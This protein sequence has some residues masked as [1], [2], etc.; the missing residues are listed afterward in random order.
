M[1]LA[2]IDKIN[3][4]HTVLGKAPALSQI[5]VLAVAPIKWVGSLKNSITNSIPEGYEDDGGFHFGIDP[6]MQKNA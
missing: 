3:I 6:E 1:T 5:A 4:I 2:M